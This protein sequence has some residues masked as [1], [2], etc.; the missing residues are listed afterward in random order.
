MATSIHTTTF[1]P[2]TARLITAPVVIQPEAV[3]LSTIAHYADVSAPFPSAKVAIEV[4]VAL[5]SAKVC[6]VCSSDDVPAADA[7]VPVS[8][9]LTLGLMNADV[10]I[11]HAAAW[12]AAPIAR[13]AGRTAG[14]GASITSY[15]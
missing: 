11:S 6:T 14:R 3:I 1:V 5:L 13:A 12:V 8:I 9:P 4:V 7:A 2:N 15:A 10:G